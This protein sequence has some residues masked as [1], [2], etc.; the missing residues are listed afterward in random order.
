MCRDRLPWKGGLYSNGISECSQ[1]IDLTLNNG[2]DRY[3]GKQIGLETGNPEDFKSYEE[4]FHAFDNQLNYIIDVK[5]RGN[6]VIE[7]LFAQHMPSTFMS[8]LT[9]GCRESGRDYNAGGAKYNTRYIQVVGIGTITD[10]LSAIKYN[11]FDNKRFTMGELLKA[12]KS[13]F[14]GYAHIR[15]LVLNHT[16]KYGNDDDYADDIML[17]VFT[18]VRDLI[19]E[20]GPCAEGHIRSTCSRPPATYTSGP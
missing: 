18:T 10:C 14:E 13:N 12:L 5:I 15:N 6:N 1:N 20:E 7:K 19:K 3:T 9:D 4:L 11:V 17:D 8:V 2:F 16:P